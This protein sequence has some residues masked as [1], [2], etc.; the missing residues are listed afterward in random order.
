MKIRY[1][2]LVFCFLCFVFVGCD[3]TTKDL[4]RL[5]LQNRAPLSYLHKM[6]VLEYAEN[7]GAFL[8]FGSEWPESLG[9]WVF[10]LLPLLCLSGLFVYVIRKSGQMSWL[11]LLPVALVF[12]GGLGNI[13]DRIIFRRHVVD[14]MN[15]GIQNFRTGIFNFADVYVTIGVLL[16]IFIKLRS[17]NQEELPKE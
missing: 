12:S 4:A 15:L 7:T 5:H 3:R 17:K 2:I 13:M 1:K 11:D 8:S 9:V 10:G 14:F 16:F 6:V